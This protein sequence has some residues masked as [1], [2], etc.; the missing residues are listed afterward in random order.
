M[1][2]RSELGLCG[3]SG[4]ELSRPIVALAPG[5]STSA[6]AGDLRRLLIAIAAVVLEGAVLEHF[7]IQA[8]VA[9]PVDFL[10][11]DAVKRGRDLYAGL[12]DV[13]GHRRFRGRDR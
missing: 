3:L 8:A 6:P 10:E 9:G 2:S 11:E 4:S 7:G 12:V 5:L 1:S 13:D